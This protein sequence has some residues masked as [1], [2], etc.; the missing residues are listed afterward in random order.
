MST[1]ILARQPAHQTLT[2]GAALSSPLLDNTTGGADITIKSFKGESKMII[3]HLPN[4]KPWQVTYIHFLYSTYVPINWVQEIN[5]IPM[6]RRDFCKKPVPNKKAWPADLRMVTGFKWHGLWIAYGSLLCMICNSK[7]PMDP[8]CFVLAS[9][10]HVKNGHRHGV[11]Y[12]FA[13]YNSHVWVQLI[14]YSPA[15]DGGWRLWFIQLT[16]L[17]LLSFNV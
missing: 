13:R 9:C 15:T 16:L 6:C 12:Y 11:S 2:A 8:S 14:Y 4:M 1:F 10:T 7:G 3:L 17:H 5:I